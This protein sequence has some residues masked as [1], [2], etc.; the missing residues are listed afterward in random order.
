MW[1][2]HTINN[3]LKFNMKKHY[4]LLVCLFLSNLFFA[5]DVLTVSGNGKLIADFSSTGETP[6][7]KGQYLEKY[8]TLVSLI[9]GTNVVKCMVRIGGTVNVIGQWELNDLN[10][11]QVKVYE[12][13][14]E[15][16]KTDILMIGFTDQKAMQINIFRL[17]GEDLVDL[18]YNYIEQ[19][20]SGKPMSLKIS[21][22]KIEVSYDEGR[23]TPSYAIMN[24]EFREINE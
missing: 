17:H 5:Q 2:S 23:E 4:I 13:E 20:Y 8:Q 10:D 24:G 16:G 18:G 21:V 6:N 12:V 14:L 9:D 1:L 15:K 11:I 7:V 22:G 3:L 19:Q